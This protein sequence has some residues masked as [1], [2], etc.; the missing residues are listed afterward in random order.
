MVGTITLGLSSSVNVA[1]ASAAGGSSS[2]S[3]SARI[4]ASMCSRVS[5]DDTCPTAERH[6]DAVWHKS[7]RL[8]LSVMNSDKH[9]NPS[10]A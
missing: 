9:D 2:A 5:A 7:E 6:S 8:G 10:S 4:A 3:G 1:V